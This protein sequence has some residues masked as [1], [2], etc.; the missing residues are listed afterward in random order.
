M[1]FEF[2][3]RP[4]LLEILEELIKNNQW[5]REALIKTGGV[6][7]ENKDRK[8]WESLTIPKLK[9]QITARGLQS[10]KAKLKKD[11]LNILYN[12]IGI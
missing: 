7:I 11:Y 6:I 12:A 5:V 1:E 2:K 8:Y 4:Q 9:E 10:S 3:L